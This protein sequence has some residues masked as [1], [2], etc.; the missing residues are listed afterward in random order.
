LRGPRHLIV[1]DTRPDALERAKRMG[2]SRTVDVTKDSLADVVEALTEGRGADVT[3]EV[4]GA[5]AGLVSAG[6]VTRMEGTLAIVGYHQGKPREIP[7]GFWNWMAF[8]IENCHFRSEEII[9]HGMNVG[10]R[11]LR[12]GQIDLTDLV[13]HRFPLSEIGQAFQ[14]AHDKPTGFVKATVVFDGVSRP[15][16]MQASS[17]VTG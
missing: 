3:F 5:Q 12:S 10:M 9:L 7:L 14:T 16:T 13:S 11:L 2:A 15:A 4:T 8:H 1:A 17:S 6:E